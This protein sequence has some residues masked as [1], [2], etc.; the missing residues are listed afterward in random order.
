MGTLAFQQLAETNP[1]VGFVH[2]APGGVN[3]NLL[4]EFGT[5]TKVIAGIAGVVLKPLFVPLRESGERHLWAATNEKFAGGEAYLVGSDGEKP[6]NDKVLSQL[7]EKGLKE[8][9]WTHTMEVFQKVREEGGK[10]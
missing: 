7:K 3:T 2:S 10:Y 6:K 1:A 9:V 4:R 8:I 5:V